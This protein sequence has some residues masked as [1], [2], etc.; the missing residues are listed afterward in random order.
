MNILILTHPQHNNGRDEGSLCFFSCWQLEVTLCGTGK[1][2]PTGEGHLSRAR[3]SCTA[4]GLCLTLNKTEINCNSCS[5][6]REEEQPAQPCRWQSCHL[7]FS[8]G[9]A[10]L[11]LLPKISFP[12][13]GCLAVVQPGACRSPGTLPASAALGQSEGDC[14]VPPGCGSATFPLSWDTP[15][16]AWRAGRGESGNCRM[17][18]GA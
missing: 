9:A 8:A 12:A 11:G 16:A 7:S 1:E 2:C 15:G 18:W 4:L 3:G 13:G 5:G 17:V 10:G 6:M 14:P